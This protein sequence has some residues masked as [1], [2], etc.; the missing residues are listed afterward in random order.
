MPYQLH[1]HKVRIEVFDV[2]YNT[3]TMPYFK[4]CRTVPLP[5]PSIFTSKG[6]IYT[7]RNHH[8]SQEYKSMKLYHDLQE[9]TLSNYIHLERLDVGN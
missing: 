2:E 1:N 8:K 3:K 6:S 4:K 5:A 7:T 9:Y